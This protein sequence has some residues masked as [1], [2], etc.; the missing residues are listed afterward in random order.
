MFKSLSLSNFKAFS[1]FQNL[2]IKPITLIFGPNS[3]GKSSIIHSLLFCNEVFTGEDNNLDVHYTKIGG[4]S[5]DLG[6]FKQF[7]FRG[8][9]EKFVSFKF[10]F[11][12]AKCGI[13]LRKIFEGKN[14]ISIILDFGYYNQSNNLNLNI[15]DEDEDENLEEEIVYQEIPSKV[16][17]TGYEIFID[18]V[19][20]LKMSARNDFILQ[21]DS[22][23]IENDFI[24]SLFESIILTYTTSTKIKNDDKEIL[25]NL[26][27]ELV[28]TLKSFSR[29]IIPREL[30]YYSDLKNPLLE[31]VNEDNRDKVI[32]N[33]LKANIPFKISEILKTLYSELNNSFKTLNYLG[34]LRSFPDRHFLSSHNKN[35]K[36]WL[37]GGGFAWEMLAKDS[38]LRTKVNKWLGSE[39]LKTNYE[40]EKIELL[41]SRTLEKY[42]S[43]IIDDYEKKIF[44]N[45]ISEAEDNLSE[46]I[47]QENFDGLL[48]ISELHELYPEWAK[49]MR[50]YIRKEDLDDYYIFKRKFTKILKKFNIDDE[51]MGF[52]WESL[53]ENFI[54][55]ENVLSHYINEEDKDELE[56]SYI[57]HLL[58][59][60]NVDLSDLVLVDKNTDTVVTHRDVG[61]G[62]SQV[63]PVLV[64]SF[65][66]KN[67]TIAI[68]QPEIHIH[69]ALQAELGDVFI[70]SALGENKNTFIIETH[71]EHLILRI[72]RRIRE[73]TR[74]KLPEG[75]TKITPEDI[76]I[77]Y[78]EPSKEGAIINQIRFDKQGK[79]IDNWP[80]GFFEESFNEII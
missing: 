35:D 78:V 24:I 51:T 54:T 13:K 80:G 33:A 69:P 1:K 41:P 58:E 28:P 39:A 47:E 73:T 68:E 61:M 25:S 15:T 19:S 30:I 38:S 31:P 71:S 44:I 48:H 60:R 42:F 77:I 8:I 55:A 59:K 14:E 66:N 34:P 75:F 45:I 27:N 74:N 64:S 18:D 4:D 10:E 29:K 11:D 67:K 20:L 57:K 23:N 62:I 46:Y 72:L 17:L 7:I 49:I 40:I 56:K 9:D 21:M 43:D 16:T 63:L 53:R 6:G 12:V 32:Y 70:E 37:P 79:L 65:G 3:S 22:I 5:V 36:N 50:N 76:S 2:P 52:L 26:L